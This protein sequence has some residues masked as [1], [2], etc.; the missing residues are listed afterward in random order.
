VISEAARDVERRIA[1]KLG[2]EQEQLRD[3]VIEVLENR[4]W[5]EGENPERKTGIKFVRGSHAGMYVR[6]PE[7]TDLLPPGAEPP[8]ERKKAHAARR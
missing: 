7:G 2:V 3:Y 1:R 4:L 5:G 6:D 8:P